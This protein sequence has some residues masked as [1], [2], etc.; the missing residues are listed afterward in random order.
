[1]LNGKKVLVIICGGI[2]AFKALDLIRRLRNLNAEVIP[3]MTPSAKHFVTEMSVACLSASK[4]YSELFDLTDETE[5]GHIRLAQSADIILV[6]PATA[7]FMAK[8][9]AGICSNLAETVIAAASCKVVMIPAMN[10]SMWNK[11]A[12]QRVIS[13][14]KADGYHFIGPSHGEMACG[15]FGDGRFEEV[16]VIEK[17][18]E[19]FFG[20][21]QLR[22]KR[23]LVTSG[24][25][26]E[27]IDPIR[28]ISNRSSGRQGV[29]IA[30][31]L[32]SLGADVIFISGPSLVK[33]PLVHKIINVETADQMYNA[34]IEQKNIDV[35]ICVAAVGD[36]RVKEKSSNKLKKES[37]KELTL[38][39]IQNRDILKTVANLKNR[40]PLVIGFAAETQDVLENA[41]KKRIQKNC[42]WILANDV[43]TS[44]DTMGGSFNTVS[45]ITS[46]GVEK[47]PKLE[48]SEVGYR[49][50]QKIAEVI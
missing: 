34:V 35:A 27:I 49:L 28:F 24:S 18:V 1:M 29:E 41:Q 5:I 21:K 47:W 25:T 2:A 11:K 12:N 50:A 9:A 23:V 6:A 36:W 45:L 3:V 17:Y 39:F 19:Q 32:H 13:T 48:K 40:P 22:G 44:S 8:V 33:P 4:V 10:V 43:S 31:A 7:D 30:A 38:T 26:Q 37:D 42:D 16:E 15:D 20:P 46:S 14:L